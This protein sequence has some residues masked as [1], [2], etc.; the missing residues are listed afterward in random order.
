M[1]II[2]D[3]LAR[4]LEQK[5]EEIIKLDQT[6]EESVFREI[7]EYVATERICDQYRKLFTA[8]AEAPAEPHEGVGVWISGFFGSGKSSFAKNL[9]Y[10]LANRE[11]L[12][13]R[14]AGLFKGQIADRRI[15]ELIDFIN[16]RIP[17][18]VI[19]FDVSVDRAVKKGTERL[20]E[21][22]YTVLLRELGYAEDYDL[23]ELEIE[24]EAEGALDEFAGRCEEKFGIPW[25]IVRKGAQKISRASAILCDLDPLTYPHAD[26]WAKSIGARQADITVGKFVERVFE[27]TARRRPGKALVFIID[28]VGQY[29]ARSADK[30]EDLRALVEQLGKESKNRIKSRRAVAPV[31]VIVTAQEKLDEVVAAID[32]RRVELARLQDRFKYR[33]DLAPA[34][35]REVAT[36]RVLAKKPAAYP[37]LAGLYRKSAGLLNSACRLERTSRCREISEE[38]FVQ[39]YPYLPHF[40]ELSIDIMSGIRLQPGAPKHLGGS[41]RTIIKQAY[42]MLVSERTRMADQEIGKLVTLDLIFELIEGNLSTEKQKDISDIRHRFKND[43]EDNGWAARVAKAI[44]LLEFVRDL[45][46]TENNLA[47]LLVDEIGKPAPLGEVQAA[48]KRLSDAQFIRHTEEGYKLQTAQEKSWETERRSYLEP[49]PVDRNAIKREILGEVFSELK[50]YR[51]KDLRSFKAGISVDGVRTGEEGQLH[52]RILVADD[53]DEFSR[54]MIEARDESRQEAN[55]NNLYWV[56]ALNSEIDDLVANLYASRRMVARYE[57]LRAQNKITRVELDCLADEKA[58]A[59]RIQSR[60]REKMA[61][62]L[63]GGTGFFRGSSKDGSALGKTLPEVMKK[64]F[65]FVVPDLYPKLEMGVRSLKGTE[66]EEVLK[67]SNLTGLSQVFYDGEG[68]L[69][70]VVKEGAKYITNPSAEIA[71]EVLDYLNREHSYGNKVTGKMLEEHFQGAGYGWDRDMLRLVLAV[72]LRAGS[73][74]VTYQGRR[75]GSHQDP[76]SRVPITNNTAFKSASFAPRVA[77]DLKTQAQ[78]ARYYEELTGEEVD[79]EEA[80]I[81]AAF[82]RLAEEEMKQLLPVEATVKANG[83]PLEEIIEEYKETLETIANSAS[84]DCVRILAGEGKS[85]HRARERM[86]KIREAVGGRGLAVIRQARLVAGQMWP[87]LE[88]R[89]SGA[90]FSEKARELKELIETGDFYEKLEDIRQRVE[91]LAD[92]YRKL[93]TALH[94]QRAEAFRQAV[95]EIKGRPEWPRLSGEMQS[96]VLAPLNS[97]ACLQLELADS[98]SACSCCR[99]GVSQLEADLAGLTGFKTQAVVEIQELTAPKKVVKRVRVAGFFPGA[100]ESAE[101]VDE[102]VERLREHLY[103]LVA[104]DAAVILE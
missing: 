104:E 97:R 65:D 61:A 39:F 49:K 37:L 43:P 26:S 60:L 27:L 99:A 79:V 66:A 91:L 11:I 57:Q 87:V 100:L 17:T 92:E 76:Q 67:A 88:V 62:A 45:P 64:F 71:K 40:V 51:Y 7:T 4:G 77:I 83:L 59:L 32:S 21:I 42:E 68:G 9:G 81:A 19:M 82:K 1:R 53:A 84:D 20:A 23:A 15:A 35:I 36:R 13:Q 31:W 50:N 38:D 63:Q 28:E 74:E 44:C 56:M 69:N 75:Y 33:I 72:L 47:A 25:R 24:L 80:A 55:R 73:L 78:A 16:T 22:M 12:G 103:K 58:E 70:L 102:A 8:I 41:N 30:I 10:V 89:G 18:E 14:A 5:I 52:L 3:L 95:E 85:F 29:V 2:R 86:K 48:L 6:D 93:Y 90:V 54:K 96:A 98:S 34:D 94:N 46:R 101:A